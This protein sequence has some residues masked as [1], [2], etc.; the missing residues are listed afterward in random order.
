[1]NP[2]YTKNDVEYYLIKR[3]PK[4]GKAIFHA[5][6]LDTKVD[7]AGRRK[8]KFSISTKQTNETLAHKIVSQWIDE[9]KIDAVPTNL[10][11]FLLDFWD[12][13]KSD[14]LK[15]KYR[16]GKTYSLAYLDA[17]VSVVQ[18]LFL[19]YFTERGIHDLLELTPDNLEEWMQH[20]DADESVS[21]RT[22]NRA[23]QAVWVALNHAVKKRLIRNHPGASVEKNEEKLGKREA[24]SLRELEDM[25]TVEWDD[26]RCKAAALLSFY[27]GA[28]LGEVR[29]LRWKNVSFS[30]GFVNIVE[31]YVEVDG[32]KEPKWG[33]SREEVDIPPFVIEALDAVKKVSRWET[34][35]E[36]FVFF[37]VDAPD[38]PV[39]KE[40]LTGGL[41]RVAKTLDITGKTFHSLRHSYITHFGPHMRP[42]E[43]R[44]LVGHS[45]EATTERYQ[46]RTDEGRQEIRDVQSK[47]IQFRKVQ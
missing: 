37:N 47:I 42:A 20:L 29:G 27:T 19:P 16:Q 39:G 45:N 1:M 2:L 10:K 5:R 3:K 18:R 21:G 31:N 34:G 14:Y 33:S 32:L 28:R 30:E 23:R 36:Q 12:S 22:A 17:N 11:K 4:K 41:A 15:N 35:P 6:F 40:L 8:V 43:L 7:T 38:I 24:F 26:I 44:Y 46:H 13:D 9:G 25:F